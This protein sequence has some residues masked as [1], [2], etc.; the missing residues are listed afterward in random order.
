MD[1]KNY[2]ELTRPWY[3]K[4]L[5]FPLNFYYPNRYRQENER[6]LRSLH[7]DQEEEEYQSGVG[8]QQGK[9]LS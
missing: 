4:A 8:Y 1:S 9:N 3:A 6:I 2:T 7:P 5:P